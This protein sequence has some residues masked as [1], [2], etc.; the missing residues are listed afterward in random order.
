MVIYI[1]KLWY[2]LFIKL[3]EIYE[4]IKSSK[5]N[6]SFE[7]ISLLLLISNKLENFLKNAF[8]SQG[9]EK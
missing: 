1:S 7:K 8:A 5:E 6:N 9:T 4:D 2:N 3:F